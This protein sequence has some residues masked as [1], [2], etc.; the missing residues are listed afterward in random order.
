MAFKTFYPYKF[1][2]EAN[3]W[4]RLPSLV[5]MY[6]LKRKKKVKRKQ[7]DDRKVQRKKSVTTQAWRLTLIPCIP[8][9]IG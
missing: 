3:S 1:A 5:R 4:L 2:K 6:R 9:K 7:R 8:Q